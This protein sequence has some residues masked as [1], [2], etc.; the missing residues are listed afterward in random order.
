M[1][2]FDQ[3]LKYGMYALT[4]GVL[5][6]SSCQDFLEQPTDAIT[7]LDSV[8]TNPD[9]AMLALNAAYNKALSWNH[10]L[11]EFPT[12]ANQNVSGYFPVGSNVAFGNS[13][14]CM[15]CFYSDEGTQEQLANNTS[16]AFVT[17]NWGPAGG[18]FNQGQREFPTIAVSNALRACNLF[19]ENAPKVP[20]MKTPQWDWTE[21]YRDQVIAEVR[22]LRA[23]LHFEF[24]R[25]YGG[26]PLMN[27][28]A[29]FETLPGGGLKVTPSAERQSMK[30]ILDFVI[31]ECD[32][33][34][35]NLKEPSEF[36]TGET[37]RIHK[38]FAIALKAK[39]LLYAASP[40]Y[41][42]AT[43]P[44]S[45]GDAR[46]SLLCLGNF[47]ANRW[48]LAADAYQDAINW[49]ESRGYTLLDDAGLGKRES[50]VVGKISP[51]ST[52]P[53]NSES[54]YWTLTTQNV[55]DGRTY[56]AGC[57][58][59]TFATNYGTIASI[60]F[61]FVKNNYRDVNGNP[62]NIPDEGTFT[63]LKSLLRTAEPRFHASVWAP[64]FKYSYIDQ[65]T[66][67]L[68]A[69]GAD[70]AMFNYHL[71][72]AN[73]TLK[74]ASS[75]SKTILKEQA[76]FFFPKKWFQIDRTS[77]Y[78]VTWSEFGLA[79]LY[80]SYAE[81]MNEFQPSN[82]QILTYLNKTRFRGGI[83]EITSADPRFGNKDAMRTEIRKER[84]VEEA[85]TEHRYFDVRRWK[86]ADDV[87]GGEWKYIYLYENG[88]GT[89]TTPLATWT[90]AQ[91]DAN[92]AKIS[93]KMV[94]LSTHAWSPK[95]HF[96]PWYQEE[97][98][99]GILV[100]NPGW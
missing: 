4:A 85:Y 93:Y 16:W 31:S 25:R 47:D 97:V 41:N 13:G 15:T 18:P 7:T 56:R 43:P 96:Y 30:R 50:Y 63:Q 57:P 5:M 10:G 81:A 44:V 71:A 24:F 54:I 46:D 29:T 55:L 52:S 74:F 99:K 40:L 23:F 51:R 72:D 42:T 45:Y 73:K 62:L 9:N 84:S 27:K 36:N 94:T 70:T 2:Y 64:G 34:I 98:N 53:K 66:A 69:G 86:I 20:I 1:K 8:Y 3:T 90:K 35:G 91:R 39:T 33:A 83:P 87:M 11:R 88:T 82:P 79:E 59:G 75:S 76:G 49:A 26:I 61:N 19:I 22:T 12:T 100:Q 95:M 37:G 28:V 80:L 65:T 32:A 78:F 89:Y 17:G 48:K 67:M 60:G 92:D 14:N 68:T 38:G 21:Q 6:L 58:I 77:T